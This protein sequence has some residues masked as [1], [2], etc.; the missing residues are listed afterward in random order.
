MKSCPMWCVYRVDVEELKR[1]CNQVR[2]FYDD[3]EYQLVR[4][5]R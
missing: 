2:D 3:A 1:R 4:P 5:I